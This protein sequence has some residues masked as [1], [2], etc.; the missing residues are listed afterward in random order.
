MRVDIV[1]ASGVVTGDGISFLEDTSIIVENGFILDMPRVRYVPYNAYADRYID[2]KGGLVIPGVIN[3]HSHGSAFGPFFPYAWKPLTKERILFNLNTHLLEGTTTILNTDGFA[4][5]ADVEAINK[6][7]PINVKMGTIH[8]PKNF[9]AVDYIAG[10]GEGLDDVRRNFTIEEAIDAGAVAIAEVGSPGTSYGTYEKGKILGKVISAR[11]AL[12]LDQAVIAKNEAKIGEVLIE[13][14]LENMTVNEAR[15]LVEKT[16]II[17]VSA[18]CDAIRESVHYVKKYNLP[19]L[20]HAEPGMK[21]AILDIAKEIG[22]QCI[23]AHVNHSFAIDEMVR[24]AKELKETGAVVEIIS[25]D[26]FGA[27]QVEPSPEGTFALFR[28][29]LVDVISTDFSG[30]YHDPILLVVQ[31]AIEE[32]VLTLLKGIQLVTSNPAK[33]VPLIAPHKGVIEPGKVADLCIV[34]KDDVSIVRYVL[35]AGRLV[36][37]EGRIIT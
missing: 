37:E 26:F 6:I 2:A 16:S 5:P 9:A 15:K 34:D 22:P 7:H 36:V 28:E 14:G 8:T 13:A 30:G 31:K 19:T 4:L 10:A 21:G 18:C 32:G 17:P 25:A 1:N 27:K 12:A 11:H 29:D 24:F 23:A 20:V 33:I 35:I 3:I